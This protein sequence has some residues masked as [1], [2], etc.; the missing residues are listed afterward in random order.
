VV[1]D[2]GQFGENRAQIL[3]PRGQLQ[4]EQFLDRVVPAHLVAERRDIVH[5]VDDRDILVEIEVFT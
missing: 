3:A 2:P 4:P 5:P 1:V